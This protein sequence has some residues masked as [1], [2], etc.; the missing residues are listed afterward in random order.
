MV[1]ISSYPKGE[2]KSIRPDRTGKVDIDIRDFFGF[3]EEDSDLILKIS[4]AGLSTSIKIPANYIKMIKDYENEANILYE[5]ALSDETVDRN[6]ALKRCNLLIEKYPK[7]QVKVSQIQ[8]ILKKEK[9]AKIRKE[10]QMVSS[11]KIKNIIPE[12]V[13]D[14]ESE[15]FGSAIINLSKSYAISVIKNGLGMPLTDT[16]CSEEY[17]NLTLYQKFYAILCYKDNLTETYEKSPVEELSRMLYISNT[18]AEKL[19]RI[20]PKNLVYKIKTE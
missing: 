3:I 14:Y 16:E 7:A 4:Q 6:E 18:T 15:Q 5:Q 20:N 17:R 10:L 2:Q 9:I 1:Q 19:V 12:L 8:E 11:E 13:S